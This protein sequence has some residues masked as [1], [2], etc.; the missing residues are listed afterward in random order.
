MKKPGDGTEN[1]PCRRFI[2]AFM[3]GMEWDLENSGPMEVYDQLFEAA[4]RHAYKMVG[5][6]KRV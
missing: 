6:P 3:E 1:E 2:K 5:Q 4:A